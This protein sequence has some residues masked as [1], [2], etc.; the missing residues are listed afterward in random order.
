VLQL[1]AE[2]L[3]DRLIAERLIVVV[4]AV[5]RHLNNLY[6]KLGVH[7]CTQALARSREL[8]LIQ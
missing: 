5:K 6:G 1:V 2:G 8:G 4:G 3:S 7:S